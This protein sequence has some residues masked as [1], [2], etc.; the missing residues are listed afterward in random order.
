MY[1]FRKMH[2]LL[3]ITVLGLTGCMAASTGQE[4]D[5]HIDAQH[6][7]TSHEHSHDESVE[8][9]ENMPVPKLSMVITQDPFKGWNVRLITE[10]FRFAPEHAGL[11]HVFGEGHAHLYVDGEKIAR[12]Y[13]EWYHIEKLA[14]GQREITAGLYTNQHQSYAVQGEP[15]SASTMIT[16]EP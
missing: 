7:H 10:N 14:P 5:H 3:L 6:S 8:V 2:V 13:G 4:A 1:I 16:V 9:P 12:V 11:E 15:I